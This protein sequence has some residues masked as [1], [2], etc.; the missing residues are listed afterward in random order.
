M[1]TA[2]NMPSMEPTATDI[3]VRTML[4]TIIGRMPYTSLPGSHSEPNMKLKKP[5]SLKAG[6]LSTST[7]ITIATTARMENAARAI[8]IPLATFSPVKALAKFS[9]VK[10]GFFA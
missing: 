2:V 6:M 3:S 5:I 8:N 1:N 9:F 4:V 7:K 10:T